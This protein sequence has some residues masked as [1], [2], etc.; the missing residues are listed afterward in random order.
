MLSGRQ[1]KVE[2]LDQL[3][4]GSRQ[5]CMERCSAGYTLIVL[6]RTP[7]LDQT[8]ME[9]LWQHTC[10]CLALWSSIT[11]TI[12]EG[13]F[14]GLPWPLCTHPLQDSFPSPG[15]TLSRDGSTESTHSQFTG[16]PQ[17]PYVTPIWYRPRDAQMFSVSSS[18]SIFA[19]DIFIH[20]PSN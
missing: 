5:A 15:F 3:S 7:H 4:C 6:F 13:A 11:Y 17:E 20:P 19:L 14:S 18:R 2:Q 12:Q 8:V 10:F 9:P 16:Q 1:V